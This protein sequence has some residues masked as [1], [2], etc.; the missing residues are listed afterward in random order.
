MSRF[1]PNQCSRAVCVHPTSGQVAVSDNEGTVTIRDNYKNLDAI[2][3]TLKKSKKW[4]EVMEY[5]PDGKYLA[6]GNHGKGK[7]YIYSV[8]E[9]YKLHASCTGHSS[10]IHC[11]DW[12]QDSESL[13]TVCGAYELLYWTIDG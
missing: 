10:Y 7:I 2:V 4:V 12:S 9:D 13:R 6:V 5:S 1:P 8:D 3:K 11:L